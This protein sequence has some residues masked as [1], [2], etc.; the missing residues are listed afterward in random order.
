MIA[1]FETY[2]TAFVG[3]P[4][5]LAT[6]VLR[7]FYG[8]EHGAAFDRDAF[9]GNIHRYYR[10]LAAP[11]VT[12]QE[13]PDLDGLAGFWC[14]TILRNP[15]QRLLGVHADRVLRHRD[16]AKC[17]NRPGFREEHEGALDGLSSMPDIDAFFRDLPRYRALVPAIRHHTDPFARFLGP[18]PGRFDAVYHVEDVARLLLG[19]SERVGQP[20]AFDTTRPAASSVRFS[21]LSVQ[22]QDQI[23]A[24]TEADF[25]LLS[26]HYSLEHSLHAMQ[27]A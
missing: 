25:A 20:V 26:D 4:G 6:G 3:V 18:D 19:L 8:L 24:Q 1:V 13:P 10:Q 11:Y 7:S 15:I 14:F 12:A 21:A 5:C 27:A 9:G 22:A 16:I 17:F 23:I 2:D